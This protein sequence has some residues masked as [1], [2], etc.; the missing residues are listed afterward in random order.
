M[1]TSESATRTRLPNGNSG[2]PEVVRAVYVH[3]IVAAPVTVPEQ[4]EVYS[5]VPPPETGE[6]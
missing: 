5:V 1:P 6:S 3:G 2:T 4:L